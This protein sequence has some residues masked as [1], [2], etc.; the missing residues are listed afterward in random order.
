MILSAHQ[1]AYLPWLGYFHKLAVSDGFIILDNVQF[2]KNSYINR[3]KI[4]TPSGESWLTIPVKMR[5][6]LNKSINEMEFADFKWQK[7]HFNSIIMNYKKS[8]NYNETLPFKWESVEFSSADR[9]DIRRNSIIK[10]R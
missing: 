10:V 5:E 9:T 1:P 6:H 7:K 3:N 8:L 2:E 4:K